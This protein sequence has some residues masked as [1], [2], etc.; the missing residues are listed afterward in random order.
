MILLYE[1][2]MGHKARET[3]CN[4]NQTFDQRTIN[5]RATQHWLQNF[6]Y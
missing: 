1:F 5:K 2:K 3:V 6:R 4:S